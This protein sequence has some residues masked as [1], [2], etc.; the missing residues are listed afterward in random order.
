M[1]NTRK[2]A[3]VADAKALQATRMEKLAKALAGASY[4]ATDNGA[5]WVA[6]LAETPAVAE[7]VADAPANKYGANKGLVPD[8]GKM[9]ANTAVGATM[10]NGM[11]K[12]GKPN[13]QAAVCM[14]TALACEALQA[15]A[16]CKGAV[17]FFMLT[18]ARVLA[19]L[20]ASKAAATGNGGPRYLSGT[21]TP[22]PKW[23]ADYVNGNVRADMLKAVS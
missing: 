9:L 5:A 13:C 17:V 15:Q 1:A 12:N 8:A 19:V 16:V 14:A 21:S 7:M 3:I 20:Q 6:M 2:A 11:G 4:P 18:E 23:A 10:A 22:C